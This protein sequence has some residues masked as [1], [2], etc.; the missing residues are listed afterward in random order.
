MGALRL[1]PDQRFTCSQCGR[2]CRRGWD[3]ALTP[4]EVKAYRQAKAER[5]Y[6][7]REDVPEGADADPFEPLP[8]GYAR[9]RKRADGAC[10]FLSPD[11]RCRIHEELGAEHKPLTCRLFPLRFHPAEG[12]AVVTASFC[13]PT[14]VKSM[15]APLGAQARD[16]AALRKAWQ[17]DYPERELKVELV[18]GRALPQDTL[19]TLRAILR[20]MLDRPGSAARPDLRANVMRMARFLEDL[21]RHRVARLPPPRLAE[22]VE[23]TG[24]YAAKS[25]QPL[26]PRPPSALGRLLFRG[27][28]FA[29]VA[30]RE[31]LEDPR[32]S[33]LRLDLRWRLLR[34][35]AHA[36]GVGPGLP[37]LDLAAARAAELDPSDPEIHAVAWNYLRAAVATL[38]TGRRPVLDE[39]AVAVGF[40]N[41]A[42]VLAAQR[43]ARKGRGKVDAESFS[44]GL[45]QAVDLT[46][47]DSQGLLGRLLGPLSGGLESLYLFASGRAV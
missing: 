45:M 2:C 3:I 32:P 43:A 17:R 46:H 4:G 18:A 24:R 23:L 21:S 37:G 25:E 8:G 16:I 1:D 41:A 27:F 30:A 11:N 19:A 13:C 9:I 20:E 31:Q 39:L 5:Y 35:L 12:A 40:L 34:L 26:P 10:G 14:V 38:G 29:V 44:E 36:H 7:E 15:G 42:G 33:G 47:A 6:R 22:Y 28:L